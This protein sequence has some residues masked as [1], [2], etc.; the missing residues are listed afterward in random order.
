M[1]RYKLVDQDGHPL[2]P[3][4]SKSRAWPPGT[5]I[6]LPSGDV[7]V[8]RF[9]PDEHAAPNEPGYLVVKPAAEASPAEQST[10]HA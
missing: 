5:T 4:V 6:S 8:V 7:L 9:V 2:G 3:F 1:F 10:E